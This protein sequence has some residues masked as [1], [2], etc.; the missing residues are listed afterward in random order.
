MAD[1]EKV[2]YPVQPAATEPPPT[3]YASNQPQ[4]TVYVQ[5]IQPIVVAGV[6]RLSSSPQHLSIYF[7]IYPI[8]VVE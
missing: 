5:A 6:P 2:P 4:P 7:Y 8:E 3:Y 1:S